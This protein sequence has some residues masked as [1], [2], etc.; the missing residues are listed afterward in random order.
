MR[1]YHY[2]R[3]DDGRKCRLNQRS[4]FWDAMVSMKLLNSDKNCWLK[5]LD[6]ASGALSTTKVHEDLDEASLN[7]ETLGR[8]AAKDDSSGAVKFLL[9]RYKEIADE[10]E[11]RQREGRR[12]AEAKR[13]AKMRTKRQAAKEFAEASTGLQILS[14]VCNIV[15]GSTTKK[16]GAFSCWR[17]HYQKGGSTCWQFQPSIHN[18][19]AI[20]ENDCSPSET[21]VMENRAV[22]SDI[23]LIKV[24]K[25]K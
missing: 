23:L 24:L 18:E 22:P 1:P 12:A 15:G 10:R 16:E 19:S 7:V 21:L 9:V 5:W 8:L 2:F 3:L 4:I 14:A 13:Q 6:G 20:D 17:V 11:K 25:L